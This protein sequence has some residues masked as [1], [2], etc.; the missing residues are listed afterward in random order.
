MKRPRI[1]IIIILCGLLL[2]PLAAQNRQRIV[3]YDSPQLIQL[4]GLYRELGLALPSQTAPFT[5]AEVM[6]MLDRVLDEERELSPA[7]R[8]AVA[9]IRS[10]FEKR[11]EYTE[12]DGDFVFDT[13]LTLGVEGYAGFIGDEDTREW[14]RGYNERVPTLHA[15]FEF[16]LYDSFY[17][18][19]SLTA[20]QDPFAVLD[21]QGSGSTIPLSF[22]DLE[23][24]YPLQTALSYGG[25]HWNIRMARET[26]DWGGGKTGNLLIGANGTVHDFIEATTFWKRFK[27]T[28]LWLGQDN[29]AWQ[30]DYTDTNGN[31]VYDPGIDTFGGYRTILVG[32]RTFF[33]PEYDRI[34]D[35]EDGYLQGDSNSI[36][37]SAQ[38][39]YRHFLAHRMEFRPRHNL[40]LTLT[41]AVMYQDTSFQLRYL[42]PMM[43]F[44]NW[45]QGG[46]ANYFMTLEA[47]YTPIPGVSLYGQFL[48]DQIAFYFN[49]Q[50]GTYSDVPPG[51][52]YLAGIDLNRP[53]KEGYLFGGAEWVKLDPYNYIDRSGI[54]LWFERR[55]ISNYM[56]GHHYLV[57]QPLGYEK[58]PDSMTWYAEAGYRIPGR[59]ELKASGEYS[60]KGENTI[61]S[62]WS[63]ADGEAEK[64][65]PSG[66]HPI[67]MLVLSLTGEMDASVIG[68]DWDSRFGTEL[69]L[70]RVENLNHDPDEDFWD[71]QLSAR[72]TYS[73]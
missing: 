6:L 53:Y 34:N 68:L 54:N 17:A 73:F 64:R 35:V 33:Y 39:S 14:V 43:I 60:L 48:G 40:S 65:T 11:P 3:P 72:F 18:L 12:F 70:I 49:R 55:V 25:E 7:G 31:G 28:F 4:R 50:G 23:S 44:H 38:E 36:A 66:D 63:D 5:E 15:P 56:G 24:N 67:G 10:G 51:M 42:N 27:F 59:W 46:N 37:V 9:E 26:L 57:I 19:T 32:N 71:L 69:S 8:R 52:G 62:L 21:K 30:Y 45:Y 29:Y 47:D 22:N 13:D 2:F 1:P 61:V 41:E 58:G 20:Q 16:Y